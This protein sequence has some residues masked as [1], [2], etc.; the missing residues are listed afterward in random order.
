MFKNLSAGILGISAGQ[1]ELIELALSF[2]FRGFD[3]DLSDFLSEVKAH[4]QAHASRRLASAKLQIGGYPLPV[5]WQ[6]DDATFRDDLKVLADNAAVAAEAG[7]RR[8]LTEVEPANDERPFHQNFEL[9]RQRLG[10]IAKV[11]EPHGIQLGVGFKTDPAARAARAF[12]FIHTLDALLLLLSTVPSKAI[13]ISVDLWDMY[14]SGSSLDALKKLG[15]ARIVS[16]RVADAPT[17][18]PAAELV[19]T[20]RLLPGEG[21]AIDASAALV[22]LAEMGFVGPVT[23]APHPE[24]IKGQRREAAVKRVGEAID[25]VWKAA[26]LSPAGK[27]GAPA[28]R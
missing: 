15:G 4:G 28:Q 12:E 8:A 22:T 3:L 23:P 25:R 1:S 10:E 5:A 18:V 20:Q 27:L 11:I 19:A 7:F 13:G 6:S 21:G 24:Q 26:G 14:V 17:D 2:G 9:C 16:V